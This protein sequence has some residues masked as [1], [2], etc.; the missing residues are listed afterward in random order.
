M[1]DEGK[2][3]VESCNF[4]QATEAAA[5]NEIVQIRQPQAQEAKTAEMMEW[6]NSSRKYEISI[7]DLRES[8]RKEVNE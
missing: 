7:A 2:D 1:N 5:L 8:T 6:Q 3:D 4:S